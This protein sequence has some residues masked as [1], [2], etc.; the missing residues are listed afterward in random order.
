MSYENQIRVAGI[1]STWVLNQSTRATIIT[2]TSDHSSL[3]YASIQPNITTYICE[4]TIW[5]L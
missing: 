2:E 1:A 5:Q 4:Q 3:L